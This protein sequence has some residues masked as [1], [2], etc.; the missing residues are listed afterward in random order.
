M[1][2]MLALVILLLYGIIAWNAQFGGQ[3]TITPLDPTWTAIQWRGTLRVATDVG[4]RPFADEQNGELVGYDID[5]ARAVAAKLGLDV[6]F[7]PT[8]FDALYDSLTSRKADMIASALPYAPE[9]GYR[10]RFSSFYF[11]AGLVLLVRTDSPV[12]GQADLTGQRVGVALGSDAD[13]YARRLAATADIQLDSSY[14]D[15]AAALAA[16]R[17]GHLDAV[18]TDNVSAL[19]AVQSAP[20]LR[21]ASALTFSPYVLAVPPEA[22]QLQAEVNRALEELREED[23]FTELN[24]RWFRE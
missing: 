21:I 9:Q 8:G 4:F 1:I 2:D 22:F 20:G 12:A 10:A 17:A 5:L 15:V 23:F 19:I 18:I 11:D 14:E 3:F 24:A 7:V 16:L 13:A 6:T